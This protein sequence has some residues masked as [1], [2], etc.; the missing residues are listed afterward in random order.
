MK[1]T[2]T[3][4]AASPIIKGGSLCTKILSNN[5]IRSVTYRNLVRIQVPFPI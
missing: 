2:L 1:V 4:F 5:Y 3:F